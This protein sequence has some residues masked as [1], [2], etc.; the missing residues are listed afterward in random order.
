MLLVDSSVW[1]EDFRG[2]LR[3]ANYVRFDEI[4]TCPIVMQEALQGVRSDRAWR[5]VWMTLSS[6]TM[7]EP[8]IEVGLFIEAA[9][10]YR[11][12]RGAGFTIR[13]SADCLIAAIAIAHDVPVLHADRDFDMIA[14]FTSLDARNVYA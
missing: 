1:V 5:D 6:A 13:K 12:G 3:V 9:Q 14:R 10:I 11:K 7:L 4:A 2:L 8:S